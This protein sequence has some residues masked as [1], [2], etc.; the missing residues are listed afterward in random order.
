MSVA[1]IFPA[2]RNS[3]T[4]L[5][6]I[7]TPMSDAPLLPFVPWQQHVKE[8]WLESSVSTAIPRTSASDTVGQHLKIEG[9]SLGTDLKFVVCCQLLMVN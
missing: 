8:Y 5:Y 1:V 4:S 2:L 3:V 9:I 6:F 7:H